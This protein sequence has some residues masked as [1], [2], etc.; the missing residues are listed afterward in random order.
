MSQG[1]ADGTREG[2]RIGLRNIDH[3]SKWVLNSGTHIASSTCRE[4]FFIDTQNAGATP[5][6]T[7]V[8]QAQDVNSPRNW[9]NRLRFKII[10]DRRFV[11]NA[12]VYGD[13]TGAP[14]EKIRQFK[15]RYKTGHTV[16]YT[17]N[18]GTVADLRKG[19][20]FVMQ[21]SDSPDTNKVN[22]NSYTRI[23][24]TP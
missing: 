21:L 22:I 16:M 6:V 20:V 17:G 3:R 19:A 11:I 14:A 5:A 18:A 13:G 15:K 24:F 12:G 7:D 4:L 2:D 8:L 23:I 10:S 1:D 9:D